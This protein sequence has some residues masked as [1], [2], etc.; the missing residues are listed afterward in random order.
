MGVQVLFSDHPS[1]LYSRFH[2]D[3]I[4]IT[5][6]D[7]DTDL[8]N[9]DN[10]DPLIFAVWLYNNFDFISRQR[11]IAWLKARNCA[12]Y[13]E[14]EDVFCRILLKLCNER[15]SGIDAKP[16]TL[17]GYLFGAKDTTEGVD[18]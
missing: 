2:S 6:A 10:V 9:D 15:G 11:M 1:V 5:M 17:K 8:L 3:I 14:K 4:I 16:Q 13:G 18:Y 7:W 12:V